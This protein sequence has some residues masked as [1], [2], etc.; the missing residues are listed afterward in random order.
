MVDEY[1][2]IPESLMAGAKHLQLIAI[3]LGTLDICGHAQDLQS[4]CISSAEAGP[5]YL[6]VDMTPRS[7][8]QLVVAAS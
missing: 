4:H 1:V 5:L 7:L 8:A 6:S 2:S 3:G